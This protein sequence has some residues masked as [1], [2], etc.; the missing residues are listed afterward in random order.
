[1]G[2]EN[3]L[4]ASVVFTAQQLQVL[5]ESGIDV[6]ISAYPV[7]SELKPPASLVK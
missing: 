1:M 6:K 2:T 7:A 4:E 5:V 3:Q